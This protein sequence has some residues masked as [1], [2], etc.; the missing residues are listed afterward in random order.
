[1]YIMRQMHLGMLCDAAPNQGH[2]RGRS[3]HGGCIVTPTPAPLDHHASLSFIHAWGY[4]VAQPHCRA[5]GTMIERS[6]RVS[7]GGARRSSDVC[8]RYRRDAPQ[9]TG[10]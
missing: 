10:Q 3:V 6:V 4:E 1:M 7:D 2:P 9:M 8:S 5:F